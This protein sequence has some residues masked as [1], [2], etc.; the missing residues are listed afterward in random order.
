QIEQHLDDPVHAIDLGQEHVRVLAEARVGAGLALEQL[1]GAANGAERVTD[2]VG[3]PDRHPPRGG[4]R[5]APVH[6]RLEL[7]NPREIAQHDHGRLDR[8]VMAVERR[9]DDRDRHLATVAP[10]DDALGLRAAL[11]GGERLPDTAPHR[12][13]RGEDLL[14]VAPLGAPR[15]ALGED[16]GRGVPEDH[17]EVAI[18]RDHGVGKAGEDRLKVHGASA[19]SGIAFRFSG[20]RIPAAR[21]AVPAA[22]IIAA[23]S[24]QRE[25]G[26]MCRRNPCS[27]AAASRP[28]RR[29]PFA[30]T[31]PVKTTRLTPRWRAALTVLRTSIFTTT[32]WNDAAPSAIS[33]GPRGACRLT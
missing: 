12:R 20:A 27:R 9:G 1:H 26:G 28:R 14:D 24:V 5:L 23:L 11:A 30:A 18:D 7:T 21:R 15:R 6:F 19:R 8:A 4:E 3:E 13:A 32:P 10:L 17:A 29:G 16:L 22:V 2:L 25:R 33:G 31:P